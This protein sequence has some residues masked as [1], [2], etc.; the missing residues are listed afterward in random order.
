MGDKKQKFRSAE[1]FGQINKD[2]YAHRSWMKNQGIPDDQFDGRPVIGICNTW[3]ELTPCNAHFRD[4]AEKV[5]QGVLEAGGFPLEFPVM[6]LGETIMRPTTM[7]YRNLVSMDVEESIRANPIDGVVLLVGCDKTTPALM[8]GAA[9]CDLPAL[10][11]SGGPMLNG[12]YHGERI[13]SG[14]HVWKFDAMVKTEEMTLADFMS[15]EAANARS[16]GH[17]MTMGTAST[18]ASMVEA[19]GTGMPSNAAIPAA[20][21]RRKTL[22][23]LAGRRVVE[24]VREDLRLSKILTREAFENAIRTNG[25]I[26]GSTNAV[27][28]LM[29]IAGRIG[30]NLS[31]DDWDRLGCDVPCIVNLMPSGE[32]LMEDFFYAGGLPMVL[33]E[34]GD[35]GFLHKD[36]LTVNGRTIW[37]NVEDA[38]CF[39]RD[40]IF[41][42]EKP[43]K[44][45]GGIVVLKGNLA[46]LGDP[47]AADI[48]FVIVRESTEGLFASVGTG[49]VEDD[50][51]ATETLVITRDVCEP[52]FDMTFALARSR[53]TKGKS[54]HVI[55]VDKANVFSAMAFFRKI[56]DERAATA[57]D[58]EINHLYVDAAALNMVRNPWDFD[59]IVT[60]NM[61]GDILSDLGAGIVGS[62][63]LAP[64]AEIG[65]THGLFQPAHGSA[66]DI[67]GTGKANPTAMFL[68]AA[69]MLEWLGDQHGVDECKNAADRLDRAVDRTFAEGGLLPCEFGGTDGTAA[70]AEAVIGNLD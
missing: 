67:A 1:W 9:S 19:L 21:S 26:G 29:A 15:A 36:A 27:L 55:C 25:A 60:E 31:L 42:I 61:Y 7:L 41:P 45:K 16:P 68:S 66:P 54:G 35:H 20:D 18:M 62:M 33:K 2:G 46:P 28:H 48:D 34:L 44:D 39:N 10:T 4:I 11:L 65:E 52:L 30:I 58:I 5:K 17:C 70:I 13:G 32:Y 6:S 38:E 63:G 49:T 8:M 51:R 24:M 43:F 57:T 56:F 64:C 53:K 69:M 37:E 14:T 47:R 22:A 12:Y 40:V 23:Q 3:S 50:R 59:V